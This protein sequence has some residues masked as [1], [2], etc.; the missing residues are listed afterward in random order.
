MGPVQSRH[1]NRQ[2]RRRQNN[3]AVLNRRKGECVFFK[4]FCHQD[5]P[6]P[7]PENHLEPIFPF[8]PEDENIAAVRIGPQ[9]LRHHRNQAVDPTAEINRPRRNQYLQIAA[10]ADHDAR[11]NTAITI[12]SVFASTPSGTR[13]RAPAVSIS[14]IRPHD[15]DPGPVSPTA[16]SL[17]LAIAT[18]INSGDCVA[19]ASSACTLARFRQ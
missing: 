2:L 3:R 11:R 5:H 8:R 19:A 18:G 7:V 9:C 15:T 14:I 6:G 4:P 10:K 16:A 12:E 13:T 17:A 1:Q